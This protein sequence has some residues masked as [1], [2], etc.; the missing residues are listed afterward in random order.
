MGGGPRG[1]LLCWG[2][3]CSLS[4]AGQGLHRCPCRRKGIKMPTRDFCTLC[5][6]YLDK[7]VNCC[8]TNVYRAGKTRQEY[9]LQVF[10]Q[11]LK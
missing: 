7:K 5:T 9:K 11:K 4:R 3:E 1:S 2:P 10:L 6:L 8:N